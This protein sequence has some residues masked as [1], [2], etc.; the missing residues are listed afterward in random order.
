MKIIKLTPKQAMKINKRMTLK[1]EMTLDK[2][3]IRERCG[4][5]DAKAI[6]SFYKKNRKA[7]DEEYKRGRPHPQPSLAYNMLIVDVFYE[8][9]G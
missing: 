5:K 3:E 9:K 4:D 6:F 1:Q 8:L 2:E 7:I